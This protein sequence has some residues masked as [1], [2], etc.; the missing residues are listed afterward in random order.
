MALKT[1]LLHLTH[2]PRN[3]VRTETAINLAAEHEAH[4]TALYTTMPPRIPAYVESYIPADVLERTS[5]D[6]RAEARKAQA[7][8]EDKARHAGVTVEWRFSEGTPHDILLL[9]ARYADIVVIGQPA[10]EN[11]R[12]PGTDNLPDELVLTAGTPVLTIPYAGSFPEVGRRILVAWDGSREACRAVHDALVLLERADRAI[13]F[14]VNVSS[15]SHLPGADIA[16]HLARHGVTVQA[17]HTVARDISVG[18][19]LLDAVS[20]YGCDMMVMGAYGHSRVLELALGGATRHV[21]R[22]MTVPVLMSH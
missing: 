5:D 21:L 18:D 4:L 15:A 19:V 12:A 8:F 10:P 13:V 14:G 17:K 2:D 20:D 22:H 6:V 16:T 9:Q 3:D 1:I 11:E 7:R